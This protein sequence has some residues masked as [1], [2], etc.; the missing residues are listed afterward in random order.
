M[1]IQDSK[2]KERGD[3]IIFKWILENKFSISNFSKVSGISRTSLYSY[4]NKT[5]V[6]GIITLI[7]LQVITDLTVLEICNDFKSTREGIVEIFSVLEG[8][9]KALKV[10]DKVLSGKA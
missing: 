1:K 9:K 7:K 4:F 10:L 8:N 3:S 5:S 2:F 6:P